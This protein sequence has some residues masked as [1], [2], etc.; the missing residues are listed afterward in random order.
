MY[1]SVERAPVGS[2]FVSEQE[3]HGGRGAISSH[4]LSATDGETGG[5]SDW[6]KSSSMFAG[7]P[8][9]IT[10]IGKQIYTV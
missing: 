7:R 3:K 8:L 1:P 6:L 2:S 5:V 9:L 10:E 4:K